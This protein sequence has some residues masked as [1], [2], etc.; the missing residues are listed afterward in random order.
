MV[1]KKMLKNKNILSSPVFIGLLAIGLFIAVILLV[2]Y[3][4][5]GVVRDYQTLIAGLIGT[6]VA[7]ITIFEIRKQ[8]IDKVERERDAAL[9]MACHAASD[10]C[11]FSI[12]H[13]YWRLKMIRGK[14]F[15]EDGIPE[16]IKRQKDTEIPYKI[17]KKDI[18]YIASLCSS[19]GYD[20]KNA[21]SIQKY[22]KEISRMIQVTQSRAIDLVD[23]HKSKDRENYN[24][25]NIVHVAE[26]IEDIVKLYALASK[27]FNLEKDNN[28]NNSNYW[29]LTEK[30]MES[31]RSNVKVKFA[32][33]EDFSSSDWINYD[34]IIKKRKQE[35]EEFKKKTDTEI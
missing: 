19:P 20:K 21:D 29:Q 15:D 10:I 22:L 34:N 17:D 26:E 12:V 28:K 24:V 16:E 11:R 3:L 2:N 31:A 5:P 1:I 25:C 18:E 30:D 33:Y 32:E 9:I 8:Y 23:Y 14:S 7:I 13:I 4:L 35:I 6:F 27:L